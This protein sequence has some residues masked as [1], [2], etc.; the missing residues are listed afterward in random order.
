MKYNL[1]LFYLAKNDASTA[2]DFYIDAIMT[3]KK[4][5]VVTKKKADLTAAIKDIDDATLKGT[6]S[7]GAEIK[8]LLQNE[9]KQ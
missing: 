5:T 8:K 7:N 3:T 1:G 2:Y 9:I 6:I 4:G